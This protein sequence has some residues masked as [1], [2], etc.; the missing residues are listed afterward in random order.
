MLTQSH[1]NRRGWGGG[2]G[3]EGIIEKAELQV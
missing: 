1:V 2:G 3:L